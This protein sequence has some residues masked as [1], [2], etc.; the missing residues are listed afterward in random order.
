MVQ[1]MDS[2]SSEEY[3]SHYLGRIADDENAFFALIEAPDSVK[4]F[5][6]TAFR[7]E[8][9]AARRMSILKILWQ[10][11][12][13]TTI[14]VLAEGLRDPSP[15][16][17][18]EAL[19]GLVALGGPECIAAI[20]AAGSRHFDCEEDANCFRAFLDEALAQLCQ[21]YYGDR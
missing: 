21:G 4:P 1:C 15:R 11:R 20:K 5:L 18:K 7:S 12:D 14:P 19:D 10:L 3:A 6:V 13:P 17:W 8:P 2:T 9:D 16:V